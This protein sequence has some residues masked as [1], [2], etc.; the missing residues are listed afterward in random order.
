MSWKRPNIGSRVN[1]EVHARFWE[2]PGVRFLRATR[3]SRRFLNVSGSSTRPVGR[4]PTAVYVDYRSIAVECISGTVAGFARPRRAVKPNAA[5]RRAEGAG[6]DGESAD[7]AIINVTA[8]RVVVGHCPRG[9]V[10][11]FTLHLILR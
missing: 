1:R 3:H 9:Q 7:R 2:R 4:C 6:L 11:N 8:I 10:P 5:W